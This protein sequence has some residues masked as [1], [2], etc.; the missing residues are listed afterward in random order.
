MIN[1]TIN[2]LIFAKIHKK[3]E[4]NKFIVIFIIKNKELIRNF[5]KI[6]MDISEI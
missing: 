6:K 1:S 2:I 4:K 3:T 5:Y